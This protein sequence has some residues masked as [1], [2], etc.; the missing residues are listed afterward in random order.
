MVEKSSKL[1]STPSSHD[2]G[3]SETQDPLAPELAEAAAEPAQ[4]LGT[5]AFLGKDDGGCGWGM[6][7]VGRNPPKMGIFLGKLQWPQLGSPEKHAAQDS[8]PRMTTDFFLVVGIWS[9]NA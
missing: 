4:C 9:S 7:G 2:F 1:P 5:D 3:V 6:V 8:A